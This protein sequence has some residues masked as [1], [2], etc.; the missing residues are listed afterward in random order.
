MKPDKIKMVLVGLRFGR[1]IVEGQLLEG[2]G[3]EYIDL[4]G[5]Y[6]LD[7]KKC[8]EVSEAHNIKAYNSWDEILNDPEI[9]AVGLYTGPNGRA[10]LI[11]N[12]MQAGKHVMTTKPFEL[13]PEAAL[14]VMQE[15]RE[16][17]K[18]VHLNSPSP[19]P[20]AEVALI[21]EWEKE[22]QLGRQISIHWETYGDYN[23]KADGSWYDD[24]ARCPVAPIFRLGIYGINLILRLS[25]KVS[26]MN[27]LQSRIRTG[28]P[29][30]DNALLSLL[31]ES[32]SIGTIYA[33][34]CIKD[35]K[36]YPNRMAIHY[37]RGYITVEPSLESDEVIVKL[38]IMGDNSKAET[39]QV[40]FKSIETGGQYQWHNFYEAVR[41]GTPLPGEIEPEQIAEA[42]KII[43]RMCELA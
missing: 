24:P 20:T 11:R 31:F 8:R 39:K 9:E 32:G 2:P 43:K 21:K 38:Q 25:G 34:F 19:L 22:Y 36:Y 14:K 40:E 12:I 13:D 5:V 3:K 16:S 37:E 10:D 18:V 29:T 30:P 7:E 4:V 23:E 17:G 41:N 15:A 35:G 27:V 33:S 28:R 1:M 26:Q 42:I 6:D